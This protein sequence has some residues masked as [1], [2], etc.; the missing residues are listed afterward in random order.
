[1]ES[2][3]CLGCNS[4]SVRPVRDRGDRHCHSH[5]CTSEMEDCDT[6][7]GVHRPAIHELRRSEVWGGWDGRREVN[8][9]SRILCID[10]TDPLLDHFLLSSSPSPLASNVHLTS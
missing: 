4:R 3:H 2:S 7:F 1:M 6:L 5:Q 9:L 8:L 10:P